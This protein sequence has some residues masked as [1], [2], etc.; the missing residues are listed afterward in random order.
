MA[1]H[2]MTF[3]WLF[4]IK[5]KEC[6]YGKPSMSESCEIYIKLHVA[7]NLIDVALE[8][9]SGM[10][11]AGGRC[12]RAAQNIYISLLVMRLKRKLT[13]RTPNATRLT[14]NI[15]HQ[16][17]PSTALPSFTTPPT[18]STTIPT[19]VHS[20][21]NP[22]HRSGGNRKSIAISTISAPTRLQG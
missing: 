7:C 17:L 5:K 2:Y 3:M 1:Q 13:L 22:T 8:G 9:H 16:S 11:P 4:F 20:E 19:V 21:A 6:V 10:P 18:S 14:P 12:P 15:T